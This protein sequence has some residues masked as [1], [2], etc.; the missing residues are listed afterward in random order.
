MLVDSPRERE[1]CLSDLSLDRLV[2]G[3]ISADPHLATCPRCAARLAAISRD[4]ELFLRE[5]W[6]GGLAARA[7]QNLAATPAGRRFAPRAVA[8]ALAAGLAALTLSIPRP[9]P[10]ERV[11]GAHSLDLFVKHLDGRVEPVLAGDELAPGEAIRFRILAPTRAHVAVIGI[12]AAGAVTPYYPASGDAPMLDLGSGA[13]LEG[14]VVL[15]ATTG[16]ERIIALLC[17]TPPN[18]DDVI[19]KGREALGRASGDPRA[20]ATLGTGCREIATT[21]EKARR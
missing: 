12:D 17:A 11:K 16:P 15:D 10:G 5:Q 19:A 7:K 1:E 18:V 8:V 4:R 14:S 2:A 3:E 9:P 6:I 20:V 13:L 21:I